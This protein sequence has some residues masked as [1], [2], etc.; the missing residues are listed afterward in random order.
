MTSHKVANLRAWDA[1]VL[2]ARR[3]V[4]RAQ[5]CRAYQLWDGFDNYNASTELW[6][7][8]A[9]T[10]SYGSSYARFAAPSGL[11]SQGIYSGGGFQKKAV[12]NSNQGTLIFGFAIKVNPCVNNAPGAHAGR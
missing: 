12:L 3:L 6:L 8:P 5:G 7:L 9:G 2:D 1:A 11:L 4:A 10:P